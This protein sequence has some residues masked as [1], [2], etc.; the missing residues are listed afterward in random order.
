MAACRKFE[1]FLI[2]F[3]SEIMRETVEENPA[4]TWKDKTLRRSARSFT[5]VEERTLS[6]Y[7]LIMIRLA[8]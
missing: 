3:G 6:H 4:R 1:S 5:E 8:E 7:A 2:F